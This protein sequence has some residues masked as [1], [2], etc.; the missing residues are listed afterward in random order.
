VVR[1]NSYKSSTAYAGYGGSSEHAVLSGVA[2][3][4]QISVQNPVFYFYFNRKNNTKEDWYENAASPNEFA[5]VR[6]EVIPKK[7]IRQFKVGG[8]TP[9]IGIISGSTSSGIPEKEKLPFHM[10]QISEGIFKVTFNQPL[11]E[12]EYCFVFSTE[13]DKVFDFGI[14]LK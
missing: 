10:A 12:G 8:T 14:H 11:T 9:G 1:D 2:S 7:I 13:T 3:M 6:V 5:L 4:Q